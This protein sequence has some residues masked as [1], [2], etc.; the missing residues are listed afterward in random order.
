VFIAKGSDA[1][2]A[3]SSADE[4]VDGEELLADY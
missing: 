1:F 2:C 3:Q 4:I